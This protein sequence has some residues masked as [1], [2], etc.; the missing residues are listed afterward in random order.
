MRNNV[1]THKKVLVLNQS[2]QPISITT[3]KHAVTLAWRDKVELIETSDKMLRTPTMEYPSPLVVRLKRNLKYNPF[4]RVELNKRNLFRRDNGECAY[5]GST[6]NLTIDHIVPKSR[7]GKSI[8]ENLVTACHNCNNEKDNKTLEEIG[9][10]LKF[11]PKQPHHL[12]MLTQNITL[13]DKWK[14]YLYMS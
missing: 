5:C 8:W 1:R 13:P 7:G 12:M 10:K 14:P 2:Y 4:G 11:K 3:V 6:D 9:F